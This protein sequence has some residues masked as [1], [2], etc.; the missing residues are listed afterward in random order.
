MWYPKCLVNNENLMRHCSDIKNFNNAKFFIQ[1]PMF[2]Y[3][4]DEVY[5]INDLYVFY[6]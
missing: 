3:K 4:M 5:E 6:A 1:V 2:L